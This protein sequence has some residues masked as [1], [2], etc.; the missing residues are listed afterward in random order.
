MFKFY[1]HIKN[2]LWYNNQES[3]IQEERIGTS[4]TVLYKVQCQGKY[5]VLVI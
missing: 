4:Y 3:R 5:D 1:I 2:L